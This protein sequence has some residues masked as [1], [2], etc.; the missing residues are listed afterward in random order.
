MAELPH[1]ADLPAPYPPG[2][3]PIFLAV[4]QSFLKGKDVKEVT[5]EVM[6]AI[7]EQSEKFTLKLLKKFPAVLPVE[8]PTKPLPT[9]WKAGAEVPHAEI[10]AHWTKQSK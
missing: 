3:G 2:F 10:P 8:I 9:T 7:L 6:D 5:D 4:V 1:G